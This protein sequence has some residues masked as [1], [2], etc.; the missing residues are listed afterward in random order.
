[1]KTLRL[2]AAAAAAL[3]LMC[4][5]SC[6]SSATEQSVCPAGATPLENIMTRT[7][8]R[9]FTDRA[10]ASDTLELLVRAGMAAPT[11]MNK[12]PWEFVVVTERDGLDSLMAVHPYSNLKTATAAII[13]CG[14]MEKAIEGEGAQYW[15]QD[16]SAATEN[17]LLAAHACGLGAVWCG[18]YPMAERVA[19]VSRVLGLPSYVLPLNIIAMG[20]PA[21]TTA[22]KDK[23]NP[24][25]V[26][27]Q[28][29]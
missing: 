28:R 18:V 27:Y 1:M 15:I 22:P 17:I 3:G 29:W 6:G 20:Y 23:W 11:A 10:I 2:F 14:N 13:V 8:V 5:S 26:H 7:S 21:D 19:P 16:C 4:A 9:Q 25:N 24:A 12:Q